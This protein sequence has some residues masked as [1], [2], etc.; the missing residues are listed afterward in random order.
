MLWGHRNDPINFHRC[1]QDFDRRLPDLLEALRPGDLLIITSDHGCDPTTPVHRPL[2]RARAAARLRRTARTRTARRHD[3]EFADVGATVNAWLGGKAPGQAAPGPADRRA[4]SAG[5]NDPELVRREY[6][7]EPASRPGWPSSS[8][9]DG[10]GS[11]RRSPSRRSP[12]R[13]ALVL[14]VGSGRGELAERMQRELDA[15]VVAVD[16]SERMVELTAARGVEAIVGDVQDLPFRDGIFDCA[17]AAWML[18]HVP[19]LDRALRELRRVLR[20]GG[21]LVAATNSERNFAELW[22][23]VGERGAPSAVQRRERR[24]VAPAPLHDRRAARRARNSDLPRPRGRPPPTS[25]RRPTRGA[26]RGS[27]ARLRRA[28]RRLAA[29]RRLRRRAVIRARRADRA[30][31]GRRASSAPTSSASSCSATRADEVPGLPDGRVPDGGLLQGPVE[32]GDVR[33]H[34]RDDRERRDDR[35]RRRARPHAASTSTRPAASATRRRSPSA[36]SSPPAA[37]RSGR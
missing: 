2:A 30:Q 6:A 21:R 12:R 11:P 37:C 31:A 29:R 19:D 7:D 4:V 23:L 10:T 33:A 1:L 25:R 8:T 26:A 35:P 3:G 16:Q 9:R 5:S 18:Y 24:G 32:R 17:V 14:E 36:R 15:R 28:A 22:E 27:P 34:R 20:P 13:A